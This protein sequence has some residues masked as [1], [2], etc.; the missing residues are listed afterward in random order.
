MDEIE[1]KVSVCRNATFDSVGSLRIRE[2]GSSAIRIAGPLSRPMKVSRPIVQHSKANGWRVPP[3]NAGQECCETCACDWRWTVMPGGRNEE[4]MPCPS[5]PK[6]LTMRIRLICLMRA[7]RSD[8]ISG[9]V[10]CLMRKPR[11]ECAG[12][13]C[14]ARYKDVGVWTGNAGR[15]VKEEYPQSMLKPDAV[16][17]ASRLCEA[18]YSACRNHLKRQSRHSAQAAAE[19]VRWLAHTL[20]E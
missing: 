14:A 3:P 4:S 13:E 11:I 8:K 17:K 12:R 7:Q 18:C 1:I 19:E 2:F 9:T 16:K 15:P 5:L 6:T 10:W 20:T